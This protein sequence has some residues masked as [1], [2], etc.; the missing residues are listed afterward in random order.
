M[1]RGARRAILFEDGPAYRAFL[2]CLTE[3]L[4]KVPVRL[5]SYCVMPNHFHLV[6]QPLIDGQLS[7]FMKSLLGTHSQRWHAFRNSAGMGAVYQGR[8]KAFPIQSDHHFYAVCRYVER[9]PLRAHLVGRAEDWP[10]SSLSARCS[11]SSTVPL[12]PWPI[13]EPLD[14]VARVNQEDASAELEAVR[15]SVAAGRPF[16]ESSWV[17]STARAQGVERSLRPRGRPSADSS[18]KASGAI[19]A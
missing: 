14:W 18:E 11:G 15:S 5:L 10:W 16:G 6:A 3:A 19:F 9:N 8:F 13:P 17:L 4:D 12:A 2:R 7:A 1:N